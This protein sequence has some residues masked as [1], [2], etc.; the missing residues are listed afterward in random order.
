MFGFLTRKAKNPRRVCPGNVTVVPGTGTVSDRSP[1]SISAIRE[2]RED[3]DGVINAVMRDLFALPPVSSRSSAQDH[4]LA[5]AELTAIAIPVFRRPKVTLTAR[6]HVIDTGETFHAATVH[7]TLKWFSC[8]TRTMN[9][10]VL[11]Q[12]RACFR[13]D[14]MGLLVAHALVDLISDCRN[15]V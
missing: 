15:R 12:I 7:R 1:W 11:F 3:Y 6:L 9:P 14:E 2:D 5:L 8:L 10:L 13:A 4:D